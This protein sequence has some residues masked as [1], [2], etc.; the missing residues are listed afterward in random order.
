MNLLFEHTFKITVTDLG[1]EVRCWVQ[2]DD[3]DERTSAYFAKAV[4]RVLNAYKNILPY[5]P[6]K[7]EIAS[8]VAKEVPELNAIEVVDIE[9]RHGVVAYVNWP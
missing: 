2:A 1:I 5:L 6:D 9:S 3:H 7:K 8:Q 4:L